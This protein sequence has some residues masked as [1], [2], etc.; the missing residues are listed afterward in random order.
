LTEERTKPHVKRRETETE[1]GSLELKG[2]TR[3]RKGGRNTTREIKDKRFCV[4]LAG[5]GRRPSN[6]LTAGSARERGQDRNREAR[7]GKK[8]SLWTHLKITPIL[9]EKSL[10]HVLRKKTGQT[11]N[12]RK[13]RSE[14]KRKKRRATRAEKK[15]N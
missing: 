10:S 7:K 1:L 13:H 3:S 14:K 6:H 8:P 2:H 12:H 4:G 11:Q 9:E 15:T 5:F